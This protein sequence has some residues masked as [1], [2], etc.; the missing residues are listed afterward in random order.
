MRRLPAA[1]LL[2]QSTFCATRDQAHKPELLPRNF[3]PSRLSALNYVCMAFTD[4]A[5][6]RGL[7]SPKHSLRAATR[8]GEYE[9]TVE[10]QA[11]G[12]ANQTQAG[13]GTPNRRCAIT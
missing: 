1:S 2:L 3:D 4:C 5:C 13:R 7:G 10:H 11:Y 9:S 12:L 6:A 8:L